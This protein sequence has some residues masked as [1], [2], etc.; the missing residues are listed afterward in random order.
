[1][2]EKFETCANEN[3]LLRKQMKASN[4][5]LKAEIEIKSIEIDLL[6]ELSPARHKDRVKLIMKEFRKKFKPNS[7][8]DLSFYYSVAGYRFILVYSTDSQNFHLDFRP[9]LTSNRSLEWPFRAIFIT[10]V[11]CH[12][13]IKDSPIIKSPVK[14]IPKNEY[15]DPTTSCD[16]QIASIPLSSDLTDYIQKDCLEFEITICILKNN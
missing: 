10:R 15:N 11:I 1:M 16:K 7:I 3:G 13:N 14:V 4:L 8:G 6:F 2:E 5:E 12:K 9:I